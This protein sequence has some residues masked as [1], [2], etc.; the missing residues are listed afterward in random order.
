MANTISTLEMTHEE[1]LER[2]HESIGASE[3]GAILGINPYKS[4]VDVYLEKVNR[5]NSL[6][7]NFNM[8]LGRALEPVIKRRF[9][10][11]TGLKVRN[12]NKIRIDRQHEFITTNL[13]G[14]IVGEK[15]PVEYK[16]LGSWDGENTGLLFL[17]N[18]AS[19]D[20]NGL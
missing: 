2:R 14:V 19:D 8:W 9:E 18:S 7:D 5:M 12:D 10:E 17:T 1:W 16:A 13:D 6:E 20:G 11:E 4:A 15:V 3:S